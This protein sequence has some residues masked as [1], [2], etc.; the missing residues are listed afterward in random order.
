[1]ANITLHASTIRAARRKLLAWWQPH[2]RDM[3]WR[4]DRTPYRVWVAEMMLQQT[5]VQTVGPY[6]RRWL[7]AFPSFRALAAASQDSVLKCWEGLGYYSRARN[8]HATARIVTN[9]L[10]GRMPRSVEQLRKLPGIGPYTAGA[11]ASIAFGADE[12]VLDGNVIRVLCRLLGIRRNPADSAVRGELWRLAG[13]LIP[14]GRAGDFNEAMMDLGATVCTPTS[15]DCPTCPLRALCIARA[16]GLQAKLPVRPHRRK[17]PHYDIAVGVVIKRGKVLI[18][19]RKPDVM[20]GGLWEFPGGK[21]Q[22]GE[23]AAQAA[24]REVREEVGIE[25]AADDTPFATVQH[26]YS[27]F[28]ITL[29]AVVCRHVR[30]RP[31]AIGCEAVR[32]VAMDDL[33]DYAF[34]RANQKVLAKLKEL[35]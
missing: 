26:A 27:H 19:R 22:S 8:M 17:P 4:S 21:M 34:P 10:A 15:P 29:Q 6:F 31:R 20:L 32:W 30:G 18:A 33:G 23:A 3:P 9:E 25:V 13:E 16:K 28:R 35:I 12:P 1:M 2:A 7:K 14:P 11:I 24:I 5:Q